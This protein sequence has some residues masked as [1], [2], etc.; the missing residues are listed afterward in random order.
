MVRKKA[1]TT[2]FVWNFLST[3]GP[4]FVTDKKFTKRKEK[5]FKK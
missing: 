5:G 4:H 3:E 2:K 1:R